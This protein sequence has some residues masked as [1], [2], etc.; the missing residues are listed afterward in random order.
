MQRLRRAVALLGRGVANGFELSGDGDRRA[1][2]GRGERG[3]DLLRPGLRPGETVFDVGREPPERRLKGLAAAG[4]I[5]DE[6]LKAVAA[7]LEGEVERLLLLGEIPSDR[8][9]S[10][11]VLAELPGE[12][13]RV[14]LGGG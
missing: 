9:Q 4:E 6:R 12:G 8:A 2:G 13:A 3:A 7:M 1:L 5:A 11:R 14:R 10:F